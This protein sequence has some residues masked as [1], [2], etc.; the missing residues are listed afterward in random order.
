M[1][2][3]LVINIIIVYFLVLCIVFLVQINDTD[4]SGDL[5]NQTVEVSV[6][7]TDKMRD[8]IVIKVGS[9]SVLLNDKLFSLDAESELIVPKI[10]NNRVY[11]PQSFFQSALKGNIS[12]DESMREFVV[13]YN[14]RA[15]V[16]KDNKIKIIDN[17]NEEEKTAEN[18]IE[19]V[20]K[21]VYVPLF[22][23]AEAFERNVFSDGN[24]VIV[25]YED[26]FFDREKD[27]DLINEL[28]EKMKLRNVFVLEKDNCYVH[29]NEK[30]LPIDEN[31]KNLVPVTENE[32]NYIPVKLISSVFG[33]EAAWDGELKE[34]TI[35]YNNSEA[36]F[37]SKKDDVIINKKGEKTEEQTPNAFKIINE[38]SYLSLDVFSDI[39][40]KN[41][42]EDGNFIIISGKDNVFEKER[43]SV[44]IEKLERS[45]KTVS[46]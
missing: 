3:K 32:R 34:L 22:E 28:L 10:I 33:G 25:S 18:S 35:N 17:L 14:N 21:I 2:N 43:D 44:I 5:Q 12:W 13:R 4:D 41:I 27:K 19:V 31:N 24:I 37:S 9:S 20:D 6:S 40:D 30:T 29:F 11:V 7:E 36:V 15:V 46:E 42:F 38:F 45:V 23:V 39:F 8:S 26:I 16:L 1:K